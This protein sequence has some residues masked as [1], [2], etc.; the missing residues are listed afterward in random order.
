MQY[1][2]GF[3]ARLHELVQMTSWYRY[4]QR[5]AK[6]VSVRL[7]NENGEE[8]TITRSSDGKSQSIQFSIG[9]ED[10]KGTSA[11][12]RLLEKLWPDA[13][14][15]N[16]GESALNSAIVRSVYLQQDRVRDFL[17]A[18]SDQD[19]FNVITELVGVGRLTELQ[20]QLE[21]QRNSWTRAITQRTKE[22]M[23]LAN[24]VAEL[25][26][27]LQKLKASSEADEDVSIP[28]WS[29]W[30]QT[31][32]AFG[33][34]P[35]VESLSAASVEA[36]NALTSA[37]RQLESL[38]AQSRTRRETAVSLKELLAKEPPEPASSIDELSVQTEQANLA[39][40]KARTTLDAAR[41]RAAANRKLQVEAQELREQQRALAQI[42]IKLLG[43]HCP[44]CAQVYDFQ[45]TKARLNQLAGQ[46]D[47]GTSS[48]IEPPDIIAGLAKAEE[49]AVAVATDT[50]IEFDRAEAAA[51]IH[52]KWI[53][54]RNRALADLGLQASDS[55]SPSQ[56]VEVV[57]ADCN[58]RNKQLVA[59]RKAGERLA[60]N[61]AQESARSQIATTES[62]LHEAKKG[63]AMH[64]LVIKSR[65]L[66]GA[67]VNQLLEELREAASRIAVD[68]LEQIEPFLQRVY[69]RIDPHPA[70]RIV[71]LVTRYSRGRGRLDAHLH[72]SVEGLSSD[73]PSAVLSSSQLNALAV[74]LFLTLNLSLPRLPVEAALLDDPIQSLD[75]I[76]LLGLVDLL[77]RTK[78][79]RQ[80][81]VSTH[82][83]RF[84]KLL[85]RKLRPGTNNQRTSVIELSGWSRSGP[86]VRQY[87]VEPESTILKLVHA[88]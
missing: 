79:K 26:K 7:A 38:I 4:T 32:T 65:E 64:R 21:S 85:S 71:K 11:E 69:A 28:S 53:G 82:D 8:V 76:N 59:Q 56:Q 75:D 67:V 45:K 83:H 87:A 62:D 43:E 17:E 72:D 88:G 13:A 12:A 2:G 57:I 1:Y 66:T 33:V 23:P 46:S 55:E 84:G 68:R 10:F 51:A 70:F 14:S 58:E 24:R 35:P 37:I 60:L 44:V 34:T 78:D 29:D 81:L 52:R 42:A 19:R 15:A 30:W 41:K 49:D 25:E 18:A 6:R 9:N 40:K 20:L 54:E 31:A 36:S 74:S 73:S 86:E 16:D 61:L 50:R 3:V 27:Q 48:T 63:L 22:E 47:T 77:R 39:V 80:L 5:Q